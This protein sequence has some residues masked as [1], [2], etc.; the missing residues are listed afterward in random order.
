MSA[1]SEVVAMIQQLLVM[2]LEILAI[3]GP[4]TGLWALSG[5]LG[6]LILPMTVPPM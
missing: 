2:S 4:L 3:D 5:K 1:A 6:P